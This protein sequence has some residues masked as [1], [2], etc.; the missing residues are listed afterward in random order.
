MRLIG[1]EKHWGESHEALPPKLS[2]QLDYGAYVALV[3]A[4]A[5]TG[6]APVTVR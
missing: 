5:L 6:T 2:N 3:P 4:V 1:R